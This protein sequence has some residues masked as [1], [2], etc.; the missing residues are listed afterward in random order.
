MPSDNKLK[1]FT[2][3]TSYVQRKGTEC[4]TIEDEWKIW[5]ANFLVLTTSSGSE[6]FLEFGLVVWF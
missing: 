3:S 1:Y 6:I 5:W 4:G 2:I